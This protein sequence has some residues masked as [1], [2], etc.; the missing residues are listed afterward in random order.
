MV[1]DVLVVGSYNAGLTV[2]ASKLPRPG[3]TVGDARFDWGPG[4]KG[5]NQ[6]IGLRRLGIDTCL[7]AKLGE[8]VFG[9]HARQVLL[10]EGLP[11]WGLLPA[12]GPTGVAFI[13][14][15]ADGENSIVVAP[16]ANL[17]LCLDDV[18]AL[19]DNIGASRFVL[20][21]LEC[22]AELA[23]DVGRWARSGGRSAV[24]NPAPARPLPPGALSYF[25]II[26]PNETEL[27]LLSRGLGGPEGGTIES[28]A[29]ALLENGAHNVVVTLGP[30]GALWASSA[31]FESFEAYPAEAR[32][33]T[34]AGDAFSAALVGAL[35]RDASMPDAIDFACRAGAYCV[36]R[37]GV[38]DGLANWET[39]ANMHKGPAS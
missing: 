10:A 29:S 38:I 39:L 9:S 27:A 34:G 7:V 12:D 25:D 37:E 1:A 13:V 3:E 11:A 18:I 26:T 6:A 21:Q 31:G 15:Q 35:A 20:L 19:G 33:T 22:R 28:Q 23:V 14:V 4:G 30:R 16:G 24:L 5:A 8:D 2:Y 36:S 32:D 17:E